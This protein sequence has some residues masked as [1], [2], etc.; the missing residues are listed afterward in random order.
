[1]LVWTH[2]V[3]ILFKNILQDTCISLKKNNI[4]SGKFAETWGTAVPL[5]I[6]GHTIWSKKKLPD[7]EGGL[8]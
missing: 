1:M 6:G 7:K 5:L 8:S 4:L 2:I 3:M